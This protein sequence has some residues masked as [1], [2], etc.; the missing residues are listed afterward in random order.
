M[1]KFVGEIDGPPDTV[2][3]GGHYKLLIGKRLLITTKM[4]FQKFR[5]ITHFRRPKF[6]LRLQFGIRTYLQSLAPSA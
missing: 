2:Y 4:Y 5:P 3:S 6:D 1:M